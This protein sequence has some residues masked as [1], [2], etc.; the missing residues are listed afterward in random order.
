MGAKTVPGMHVPML[1]K[2]TIWRSYNGSTAKD[3]TL[4]EF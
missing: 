4:F 2:E 1:L 3:V